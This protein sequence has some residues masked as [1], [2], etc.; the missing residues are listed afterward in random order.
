MIWTDMLKR[1]FTV[2]WY[3]DQR[4]SDAA[5]F[6]VDVA[7]IVDPNI[8]ASRLISATRQVRVGG[9]GIKDLPKITSQAGEFRKRL[10]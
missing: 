7:A 4:D 8:S 3:K 9:I 1:K 2:A 10:D 5:R 6:C